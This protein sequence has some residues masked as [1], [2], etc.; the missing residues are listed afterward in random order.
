VNAHVPEVDFPHV[1][2]FG[3]DSFV[4]I[5]VTGGGLTMW[6]AGDTSDEPRP[7]VRLRLDPESPVIVATVGGIFIK[8]LADPALW[9]KW[10]A[11]RRPG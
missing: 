9:K 10:S 11:R 6:S 1:T 3:S 2:E 5:S 8:L 7:A 4:E